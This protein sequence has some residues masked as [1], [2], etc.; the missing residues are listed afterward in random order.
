MSNDLNRCEFIGRLGAD[1]DVRYTPA[2]NAVANIRIACNWKSKDN[3][4]VEWIGVVFFGR[5][6]E[7]VGEYLK[8]GSRIFVAGRMQTRQWQDKQ[9]N[10]R[11]TTEVVA[12]E[13][14]ILDGKPSN[15]RPQ[16][17]QG[18]QYGSPQGQQPQTQQRLPDDDQADD[19]PFSAE[20]A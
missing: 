4:G 13:M 20:V 7:V 5:L 8:K 6:A 3:E 12:N 18:G 15:G 14:Q 11:Y 17:Q 10:D 16:Q 2:K 9:G 1:P 19:I